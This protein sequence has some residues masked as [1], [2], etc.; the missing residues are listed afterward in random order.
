MLFIPSLKAQRPPS[1]SSY[2]FLLHQKPSLLLELNMWR[3][4]CLEDQL[5]S[6]WI[7][8]SR[9][10]SVLGI[11][12]TSIQVPT[13]Y[14]WFPLDISLSPLQVIFILSMCLVF[15]MYR[16]FQFLPDLLFEVRDFCLGHYSSYYCSPLAKRRPVCCLEILV[17]LIFMQTGTPFGS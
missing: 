7:I 1:L 11:H 17:T 12:R 5:A 2:H 6:I 13:E 16:S 15:D 3:L 8:A 10:L 9:P 14:W 4:F